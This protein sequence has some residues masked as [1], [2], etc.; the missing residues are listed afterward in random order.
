MKKIGYQG[1]DN[2]KEEPNRNFEVKEKHKLK[3]FTRG[4]K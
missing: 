4:I 3:I 1:K 2:I